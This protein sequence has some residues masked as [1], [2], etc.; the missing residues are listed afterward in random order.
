MISVVA[1]TVSVACRVVGL[2]RVGHHWMVAAAVSHVGHL[3]HTAVGKVNPVAATHTS[4]AV[5]LLTL[6]KVGDA[7]RNS[8]IISVGGGNL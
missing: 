6:T 7:S 3:L 8:V 1:V 2:A 4:V 5:A